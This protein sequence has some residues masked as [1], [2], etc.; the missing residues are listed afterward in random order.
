MNITRK[1][2]VLGAL[3]TTALI[4]VGAQAAAS[5]LYFRSQRA[6]WSRVRPNPSLD[7]KSHMNQ[8]L[9]KGNQ[10]TSRAARTRNY[11]KNRQSDVS[12]DLRVKLVAT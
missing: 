2:A 7:D 8:R 9:S 5:G 10:I 3:V 6:G 4:S 11:S 1:V 12:G